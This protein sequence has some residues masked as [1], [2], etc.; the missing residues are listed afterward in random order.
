M[1]R[2]TVRSARSSDYNGKSREE[3]YILDYVPGKTALSA[4]SITSCLTLSST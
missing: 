4:T 2:K 1:K 3:I